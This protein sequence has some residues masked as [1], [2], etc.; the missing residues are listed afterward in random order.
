VNGDIGD[1]LS[2]VAGFAAQTESTAH[3]NRKSRGRRPA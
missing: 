1:V 2:A 3:E